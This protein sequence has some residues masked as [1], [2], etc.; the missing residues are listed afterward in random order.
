MYAVGAT[1][2]LV[3]LF[4]RGEIY[5][6]GRVESIVEDLVQ[7]LT[8]EVDLQTPGGS[9]PLMHAPLNPG[10]TVCTGGTGCLQQ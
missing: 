5:V 4:G 7:L 10:A 9:A 2:E 3:E 6:P 1:V 8:D